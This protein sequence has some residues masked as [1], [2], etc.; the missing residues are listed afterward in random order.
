[1]NLNIRQ[2]APVH[3]T[4]QFCGKKCHKIIENLKIVQS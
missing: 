3:L 4:A 2:L 1:M